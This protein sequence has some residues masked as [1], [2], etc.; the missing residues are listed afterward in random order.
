MVA[1][2]P[3]AIEDFL[4]D[5]VSTFL[6]RAERVRLEDVDINEVYQSLA[7][8]L[9]ETSRTLREEDLWLAANATEGYPFM[10]QLV[11]YHIWRRADDAGVI[12]HQ[13]VTDGIDAARVRLGSLVHATSLK[14]LSDVDRTFLVAM[15]ADYGP[16][17]ISD[18]AARLQREPNYVGVYRERLL[19]AG[20]IDSVG[21][22]LVDFALPHLRQYLRE[23]ATARHQIGARDVSDGQ[24]SPER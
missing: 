16:S 24:A 23:H 9:R 5:D 6:R 10:I 20:M 19:T 8:T 22:G 3:R 7:T 1:G 15:A 13:A 2:L 12:S 11:G 17:R 21:F 4:N 18:I 14:D